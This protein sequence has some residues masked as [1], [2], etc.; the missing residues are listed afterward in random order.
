MIGKTGRAKRFR[1]RLKYVLGKEGA[2]DLFARNMGG[3]QGV[4]GFTDWMEACAAESQCKKPVYTLILSWSPED[5]VTADQ[6]RDVGVRV[7]KKLGLEEH[8][9]V[10]V[11]HTDEEHPHL[12]IIVN[13]VHPHHGELDSNGNPIRVWKGWKDHQMIESELRDIEQEYGWIEVPGRRSLREGQAIPEGRSFSRKKHDEQKA[14]GMKAE[15][16]LSKRGGRGNDPSD[17]LPK[18]PPEFTAPAHD[19]PAGEPAFPRTARAFYWTWREA[20]FG[21]A[22]CQLLMARM[23]EVGYGVEQ[24]LR[25]AMNWYGLAAEQGLEEAV[26][27]HRALKEEGYV[28]SPPRPRPH[29]RGHGLTVEAGVPPMERK[30]RGR[31]EVGEWVGEWV[32]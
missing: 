25:E 13:R 23:Y 12:H 6:M 16:R 20:W 21:N 30:P 2:V 10:A 15:P 1:G 32:R 18:R 5:D 28:S 27:G 26:V 8:Q 31:D 17:P 19:R 7:L 9:A 22:Q 11:Q 4:E 24:D 14:A 29:I 3:E